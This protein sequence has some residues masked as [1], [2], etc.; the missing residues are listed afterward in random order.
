MT[1]YFDSLETRSRDQRDVDQL[2][3]LQQQV[4]H[5]KAKTLGY[6]RLLAE[7]DPGSLTSL[8]ALARL[9]VTRKSDLLSLQSRRGRFMSW[10]P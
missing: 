7:V 2:A 10:K 9:P 4:T 5:A 1:D 3:A 8:A 6:G